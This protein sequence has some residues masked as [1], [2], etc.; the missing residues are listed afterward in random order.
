MEINYK[1]RQ[2]IDEVDNNV[3]LLASAGTGKTFTLAKRV[4]NIINLGK[5]KPN[6]ILCI[7]FTNRACKEMKDRISLTLGRNAK[8]IEVKTIH[9]FCYN[10]IKENV[11]KQDKVFNDFVILDENDCIKVVERA[12]VLVNESLSTNNKLVYLD[13]IN[14]TMISRLIDT[15]KHKRIY[16]DIITDN[17]KVDFE[18]VLGNDRDWIRELC[19]DRGSVDVLVF[20]F[21]NEHGALLGSIYSSLLNEMN[22]MDFSDLLINTYILLKD[23]TVR[24][25]LNTRYK[26]INIDEVQDVNI[27]EYRILNAIMEG[28]NALICG[29]FFQTIYEWRG[30]EPYKLL[31]HFKK[32]F[33]PVE[34][35]L[36]ENYRATNLLVDATFQTLQNLFKKEVSET[37]KDLV[38]SKSTFVGEKIK[39]GKAKSILGE[40]SWIVNNLS[41]IEDLSKVCILARSNKYCED[42]S[43]ELEKLTENM[44]NIN[45]M[46]VDSFKFFRLQEIKDILAFLKLI[47]NKYDSVS[48]KRVLLNYTSKVDEDTVKLIENK[49][50]RDCGIKLTDF[51]EK[52]IA[53]NLDPYKALIENLENVV[54]FDVESTGTNVLRD[55]VIQIAAIKL[56]KSG[57]IKESFVRFLKPNLSVGDSK[58][59]H[60][61]SDEYLEEHGGERV[62]VFE[63][64]KDFTK[65][66]IFVGHNVNYD[67]EIVSSN[68]TK[69]DLEP[70]DISEVYD[71]LDIFRR[72]YPNLPNHKLEFLG[73]YFEVEHKSTHDAYDDIEA[74]RELLL[75]ALHQNI[76]PTK[77]KRESLI[78]EHVYKFAKLSDFINSMRIQCSEKMPTELIDLVVEQTLMLQQYEKNENTNKVKNVYTFKKMVKDLQKSQ[79]SSKEALLYVLSITSLSNSEIDIF[80]KESKKIP[81]ITIHQ[82]KGLEF[83]YV[84]LSGLA[85]NTFPNKM[86]INVEG[87]VAEEEKRAFYVAITRA[88]KELYL[89]CSLTRFRRDCDPS[90]FLGYLPNKYCTFEYY[91]GNN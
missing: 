88:K 56:D 13:L 4:E 60:G 44:D 46:L 53:I 52:D 29:D 83:D 49:E 1:Q 42:L 66:C 62:E 55:E 81:I 18:N 20:D 7:T 72:F 24:E 51:V 16:M 61:F 57:N 9:S 27:L 8:D 28:N 6:E 80:V 73:D 91:K 11:K 50:Y 36:H 76:I 14:P 5:A 84:F 68:L 47:C 48:L 63:D 67:I 74:T 33:R 58:H 22:A 15:L 10:V 65:G 26:Y 12:I 69:C 79:I 32:S 71:T 30:S 41:N 25:T 54:V 40:A 86:S 2:V 35:V 75:H 59:V 3:L 90:E 45:F 39:V 34:I 43:N 77:E 31:A 21:F 17:I 38:V 64:F 23:E 19:Y 85:Q 37:Y 89:S 78:K 87:I 70:L 82:S